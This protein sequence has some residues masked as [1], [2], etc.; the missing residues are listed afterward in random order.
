M[1]PIWTIAR[2][3]LKA[4]FDQPTGYILLVVF[5]GLNDYLFFRQAYLSGVA[6]LRPMLELFP[7]FFLFFVPAVT[8]R[9]LAEDLRAGTLEVV[10][11]QPITELELVAGKYVGQLLFIWIALASTL[12]IPLGLSLGA[13]LHVGVIFAQYVGSALLAAAF[14]AIGIWAS[15]LGRNQ[16]TAFI[17]GVAVMFLLMFIG[18]NP[19][20]VGL[21]PVLAV[22]AANL[23]VLSHFENI[24]RGLLD[25]RDVIYFVT[26][27]AIFL[28]LAYA[29]LMGRKLAPKGDTVKR[30]RLGTALLVATFVIANLFGRHISGRLDLTPGKAYTLSRATKNLVGGLDDIVTIKLFMSKELPSEIAL[31][32]RDI[33]DVLSDFRSAGGGNVRLVRL[34]P[35]D[36]ESD[37]GAEAQAL[38]IPP[39]QFNVVGE[40]ELSVKEGYLGLAMQYAD[41]TETIPF[42]QRTEDLEY[43]LATYVRT[44]TRDGTPTIGFVTSTPGLGMPGQQPQGPTFNAFQSQLRQ[45]YDVKN[46]SL[47]SDSVSVNELSALVIAGSPLILADSLA[48]KVEAYL[49]AGGGA[50]IMA[51]GMQVSPQPNQPFARAV[52]VAW[53]RILESYGITINADMVYDL[54]SNEQ[55]SLA[56]SFGRVFVPYPFWLRAISTKQNVVNQDIESVFMPWTSQIDTTRALAGT[57]TP[58]FVTSRA[59]GVEAGQALIAPQRGDYAQDDLESRIVAVLVNPLAEGVVLGGD[60][61][62]ANNDGAHQDDEIMQEEAA[63]RE[64]TTVREDSSLLPTKVSN[65]PQG[66]LVVIGNGEFVAD[67]WMRNTPRNVAFVMNAVD[68]LAQDEAL[69]SIRAKDRAPP[70]LVF[71]SDP[72][73]DFVKWGNIV[74]VPLLLIGLAVFRLLRRRK[75]AQQS[76][77][78]LAAMEVA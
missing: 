75:L 70:A 71:E 13:D 31:L 62:A 9:A 47:E 35:G 12:A 76:Y 32:K 45:T 74:G 49:E 66:R 63:A 3:E 19:L 42:I 22:A 72:K 16:I 43:R 33:E 18:L 5:V 46:L 21:P 27:A 11:A 39:V 20:V 24:A 6:S 78:P 58:L 60:N 15:S 68:W 29:K 51:S 4:L 44:L 67:N 40:G 10:L 41:Q 25:L 56:T 14:C 54:A 61:E 69:I 65:P 77:V 48:E 57:V 73:R 30:L 36:E 28:A 34:D 64:D 52:P 50:L 59:A 37:A 1:K 2:R 7:W 38:G 8:M 26:V 17:V 53:N 55:A 23:G